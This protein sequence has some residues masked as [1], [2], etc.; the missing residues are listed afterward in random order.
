[1]S[2]IDL[3][4]SGPSAQERFQQV[5]PLIGSGMSVPQG[6]GM[7]PSPTGNVEMD[8]RRYFMS[9][10]Y[11]PADWR[12]V[13]YIIDNPTNGESHWNPG[14]VNPSSGAAGIAQNINGYGQDYS[15]N[16]PMEQIRWLYDYLGSHNYEGYG[17]GIDAAYAHKRATG[18]Y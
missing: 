14:A 6:G 8:A 10:G 3:L 15:R 13:D 2:L 1:M 16:D 18:W 4:M 17:T 9:Q 7:A 12:K 11:S 5:L